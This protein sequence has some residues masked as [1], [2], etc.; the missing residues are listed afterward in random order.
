MNHADHVL[1]YYTQKALSIPGGAANPDEPLRAEYWRLM[2]CA[3]S[4]AR[5]SGA[6]W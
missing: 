5:L 2:A 3:H 6:L 4:A 1:M